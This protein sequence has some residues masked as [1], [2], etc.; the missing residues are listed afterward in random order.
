MRKQGTFTITTTGL[1][2]YNLGLTTRAT[3]AEFHVC[4]KRT[5]DDVSHRSIGWFTE[6]SNQFCMST[7]SDPSGSDSFNSNA[8]V[9]QHY[10]RFKGNITK[11]LSASFDSF[12]STGFKL[13]VQNSHSGYQVFVIV[14]D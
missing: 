9:I 7:F 8:H 14:G 13:N 1:V 4:E 2:T 12:T 10:E 3:W 5:G 11:M 6:G